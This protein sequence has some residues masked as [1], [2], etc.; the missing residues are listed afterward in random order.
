MWYKLDDDGN[1]RFVELAE[2]EYFAELAKLAI[3]ESLGNEFALQGSG[4]FL[5]NGDNVIPTNDPIPKEDAEKS[6]KHPFLVKTK[7]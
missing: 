1:P 7:L 5:S 3:K 6:C 2:G 4:V